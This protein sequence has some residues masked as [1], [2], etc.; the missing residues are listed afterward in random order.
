MIHGNGK[1]YVQ[2]DFVESCLNIVEIGFEVISGFLPEVD[3]TP[4]LG[5][6]VISI[7]F[8]WL[9]GVIDF[10]T[11]YRCIYSTLNDLVSAEYF[12]FG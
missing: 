2:L 11:F 8:Y 1:V 6:E 5:E 10:Y 3:Q 12:T 9:L 4:I 7:D